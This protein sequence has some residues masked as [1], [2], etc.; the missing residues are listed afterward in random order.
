MIYF[1]F[2]ISR[3]RRLCKST[4]DCNCQNSLGKWMERLAI[5]RSIV[6][7]PT[8]RLLYRWKK[9]LNRKSQ[10]CNYK[11]S[12]LN[13]LVI[14]TISFQCYKDV[15]NK[16]YIQLHISDL[17]EVL[18]IKF[19]SGLLMYLHREVDIFEMSSFTK[20]FLWAFVME[21]KVVPRICSPQIRF[22]YANTITSHE[23]FTRTTHTT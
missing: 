13:A 6:S 22:P 19:N 5:L 1:N 10:V 14:Q 3:L 11:K 7:P 16:L 4:L 15:F 17:K 2:N 23:L 12:L 20:S 18:L 8:S 21:C 9:T